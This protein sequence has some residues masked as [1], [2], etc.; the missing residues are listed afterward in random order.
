MLLDRARYSWRS[1]TTGLPCGAQA[2]NV[3]AVIATTPRIPHTEA[4]SIGSTAFTSKSMLRIGEPTPSTAHAHAKPTPMMAKLS[5]ATSLK[6]PE[7]CCPSHPDAD[8]LRP[9]ARR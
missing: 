7:P 6:M 3:E 4:S 5:R 2:G 8:L 9:R 1:A